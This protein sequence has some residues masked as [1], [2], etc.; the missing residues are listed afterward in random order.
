MSSSVLDDFQEKVGSGDESIDMLN[1]KFTVTRI[2][3]G[4]YLDRIRF[5]KTFINQTVRS[6]LFGNIRFILVVRSR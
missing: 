3:Q 6:G 4:P 2:F 5:T 1:G